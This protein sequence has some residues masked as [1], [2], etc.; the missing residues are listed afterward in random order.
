MWLGVEPRLERKGQGFLV[1]Q[2][3]RKFH[4]MEEMRDWIREVKWVHSGI[5]DMGS[6]VVMRLNVCKG[7][8]GVLV[9]ELWGLE[10]VG[11]EMVGSEGE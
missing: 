6:V 8:E 10:G 4:S 5:G 7:D 1:V 9:S 11:M 3:Q 2:S